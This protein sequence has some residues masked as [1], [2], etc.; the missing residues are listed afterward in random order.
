LGTTIKIYL[1]RSRKALEN[2][3]E[4]DE[5]VVGSSENETIMVVEDDLDVRPIWSRR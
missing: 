5:A 3:V 4:A 1:P 2:V